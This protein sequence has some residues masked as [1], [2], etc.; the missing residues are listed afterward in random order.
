MK[1]SK[2]PSAK[3]VGTKKKPFEIEA[4]TKFIKIMHPWI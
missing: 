3:S 4:N 2:L 1:L